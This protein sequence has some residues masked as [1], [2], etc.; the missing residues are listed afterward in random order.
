MLLWHYFWS[1]SFRKLS[2]CQFFLY[3]ERNIFTLLEKKGKLTYR[4]ARFV[5]K[6]KMVVKWLL[7]QKLSVTMIIL[8]KKRLRWNN[9]YHFML[10]PST[11]V[12]MFF[13]LTKHWIISRHLSSIKRVNMWRSVRLQNI[14]LFHLFATSHVYSAQLQWNFWVPWILNGVLWHKISERK[15]D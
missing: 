15:S 2:R 1:A 10:Y 11:I 4:L 9:L 7:I 3:P 8:L 5:N 13:I 12:T 14:E 6:C